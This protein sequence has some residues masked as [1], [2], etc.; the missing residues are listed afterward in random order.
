MLL[1]HICIIPHHLK[2][3]V[4][5]HTVVWHYN[6]LVTAP[7]NELQYQYTLKEDN[8]LKVLEYRVLMKMFGLKEE[9]QSEA[10]ESCVMSINLSV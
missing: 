9:T 7:L 1:D 2:Y 3:I 4:H 5:Y 6:H 8:R 10:D